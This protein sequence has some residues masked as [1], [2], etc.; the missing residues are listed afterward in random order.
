[1][2]NCERVGLGLD[3]E[4]RPI[5]GVKASRSYLDSR[6]ARLGISSDEED[7]IGRAGSG[8]SPP[9]AQEGLQRRG[10]KWSPINGATS[11]TPGS[12]EGNLSKRSSQQAR[13]PKYLTLRHAALAP[14]RTRK[15][16]THSPPPHARLSPT[17]KL[18]RLYS[19]VQQVGC[20]SLSARRLYTVRCLATRPLAPAL[21]RARKITGFIERWG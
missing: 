14:Y 10:V 17:S 5:W 2:H 4:D 18:A 11:P 19:N 16:G 9:R 8:S 7:P 13:R 15:A 6:S 20:I 3:P 12:S 1:M 21:R